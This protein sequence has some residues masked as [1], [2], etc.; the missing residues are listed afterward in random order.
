MSS[1][2][3]HYSPYHNILSVKS[4][5]GRMGP[6]VPEIIKLHLGIEVRNASKVRWKVLKNIYIGNDGHL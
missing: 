3:A 4:G 1:N 5:W 2:T 6:G